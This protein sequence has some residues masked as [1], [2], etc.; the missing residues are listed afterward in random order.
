M[1]QLSDIVNLFTKS[2]IECREFFGWYFHTDHGIWT[3]H[4][5]NFYLNRN[6][7]TREEI[8]KLAEDHKKNR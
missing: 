1:N 5:D 7:I 3:M 6:L 2:G 8:K 4:S